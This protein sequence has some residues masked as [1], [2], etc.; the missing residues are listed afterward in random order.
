MDRIEFHLIFRFRN[1]P[2]S[3]VRA[4]ELDGSGI[5]TG[6]TRRKSNINLN[7]TMISWID[8]A[9]L[10]GRRGRTGVRERERGQG[11]RE[12]TKDTFITLSNYACHWEQGLSQCFENSS[13]CVPSTAVSCWQLFIC[14]AF[15]YLPISEQSP[16]QHP[17]INFE[18]FN[19]PHCF[20]QLLE[21]ELIPK[22][23]RYP[24][25]TTRQTCSLANAF[26]FFFFVLN[27]L[28]SL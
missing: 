26:Q 19:Y 3:I 5:P 24:H 23:N 18:S 1:F 28:I 2:T 25:Q 20:D 11:E 7:G 10:Y 4:A 12:G 27:L 13:R 16:S 9:A 6:L 8:S 21:A 15:G 17:R 14:K 22:R